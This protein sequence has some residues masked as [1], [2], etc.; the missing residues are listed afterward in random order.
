MKWAR[1]FTANNNI[2]IKREELAVF[3][4]CIIFKKLG[5]KLSVRYSRGYIQ[6]L[7]QNQRVYPTHSTN[8]ENIT[9]SF[10]KSRGYT[11]HSQQIQRVYSTHST[12]L[13]DMPH[14]FDK[15]RKYTILN[16]QNQTVYTLLNRQILKI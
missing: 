14:S 12:K 8:P 9:Y 4:T 3:S 10:D 5:Y 16:R 15:I 6:L 7:R 2:Q 1:K 11:L 13:E